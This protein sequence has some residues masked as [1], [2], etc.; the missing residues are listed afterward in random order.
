MQQNRARQSAEFHPLTLLAFLITVSFVLAGIF[1]PQYLLNK[2]KQ[3]QLSSIH[4][5]PEG[6]YLA[7]ETAM[8]R[9][10]SGQLSSLDRMKLIAG[11]WESSMSKCDTDEGFLTES[12][13][14]SLAKQ[15]LE[16]FYQLGIY[17]CS[18]LSDYG[19]WYSWTT[20]LYKYTDTMFHTYTAYLW[21]IHFT[22]YDDSMTQ[23]LLMTENGTILNVSLNTV[24][25]NYKPVSW[26]YTDSY[27]SSVIGEKRILINNP[28]AKNNVYAHLS[29]ISYPTVHLSDVDFLNVY[30][31]ELSL[32]GTSEEYT[33]YQ[34]STADTYGIGITPNI[35]Q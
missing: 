33:I 17:P 23:T 5:A 26:A 18:L 12:E 29:N 21:V 34:Y 30:T 10:A 4:A 13:A 27:I 11:T 2:I 35:S 25:D 20:E 1:I 19:N 28:P 9:N 15:Q 31:I 8:S 16:T 14:V 32:N 6:Y 7:S 22:K 3:E 24:F